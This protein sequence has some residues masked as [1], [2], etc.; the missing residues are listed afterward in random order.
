MY[1]CVQDGSAEWLKTVVE[2]GLPCSYDFSLINTLGEPV[3]IRAWNIA[4]LPT[5]SFSTENGIIIRSMKSEAFFLSMQLPNMCGIQQS[6]LICNSLYTAKGG[7]FFPQS[8]QQP[9]FFG[10]EDE[11][12]LMC[13]DGG[14]SSVVRTSEFKPE[15]PGFDPLAG[16]TAS[17]SIPPCQLVQTHLCLIPLCVYGKDLIS[18]CRKRG[19][20][21]AGDM[22]SQK[23]CT[24]VNNK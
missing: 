15:E 18:I 16:Q 22:E 8:P 19:G 10:L 21:T 9:N 6:V 13:P 11:F 3:K 14:R 24:Q 1:V 17:F 12:F 4:G 7:F 20:L 23:H 5:D 2:N